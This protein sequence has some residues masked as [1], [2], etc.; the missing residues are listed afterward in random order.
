MWTKILMT[1]LAGIL[2]FAISACGAD[3]GIPGAVDTDTDTDTD[4][5]ADT[6]K[7]LKNMWECLI[8]GDEAD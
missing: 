6:D 3:D 4:G 1:M 5:D 2:M 7:D 8:C